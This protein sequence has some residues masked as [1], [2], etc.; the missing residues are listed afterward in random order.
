MARGVDHHGA[1]A[2]D[3]GGDVGGPTARQQ[4]VPRP[5]DDEFAALAAQAAAAQAAVPSEADAIGAPL[6]PGTVPRLFLELARSREWG[7]LLLHS[8]G[9]EL[10]VTLEDG[11]AVNVQP[12]T[13][14]QT[15]QEV[16]YPTFFWGEGSYQLFRTLAG[17]PVRQDLDGLRPWDFVFQGMLQPQPLDWLRSALPADRRLHATTQAGFARHALTLYPIQAE[18]LAAVDGTKSVADL[19]L[20]TELPEGE[21]LSLLIAFAHL[22][23]VEL[24]AETRER[25]ISFGL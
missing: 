2:G 4:L 19:L 25:R 14:D 1:C 22:G 16:L 3:S 20:L 10:Q 18:L 17:P 15:L 7:V 5:F 23:L 11:Q 13:G 8:G 24:R 6:E 12:S 9:Q 21:A